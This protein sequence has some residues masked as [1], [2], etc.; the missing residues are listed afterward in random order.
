MIFKCSFDYLVKKVRRDE[1]INICMGKIICEG[2]Q[3][4]MLDTVIGHIKEKKY[5]EEKCTKL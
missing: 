1:L 5:V 2:L 3:E 4:R